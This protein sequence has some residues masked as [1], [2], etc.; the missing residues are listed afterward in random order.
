MDEGIEKFPRGITW[1]QLPESRFHGP[2]P[3]TIPAPPP[4]KD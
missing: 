4:A 3:A 1:N 2:L